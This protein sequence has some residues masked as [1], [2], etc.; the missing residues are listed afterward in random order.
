MRLFSSSKGWGYSLLPLRE[1]LLLYSFT[2]LNTG[3]FPAV[4]RLPLQIEAPLRYIRLQ[5]EW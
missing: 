4:V 2:P 3:W 1:S 5:S